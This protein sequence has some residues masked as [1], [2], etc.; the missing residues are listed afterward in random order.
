MLIKKVKLLQS[1]PNV[2]RGAILEKSYFGDYFVTDNYGNTY[3][4]NE[5]VVLE[6][7][8]WFAPYSFTVEDGDVFVG[9]I[10]HCVFDINPT[11]IESQTVF[12][13][14]FIKNPGIINGKGFLNREKAEQ[15]LKSLKPKFKLGDI[16]IWKS[17]G[18]VGKVIELRKNELVVD[19]PSN[20]EIPY[21][22]VILAEPSQIL[23]YYEQQGWVKGAKF[24]VNDFVTGYFS[25]IVGDVYVSE[26][27]VYVKSTIGFGSYNIN[28]CELIKEPDYPK[29]LEDIKSHVLETNYSTEFS[30][31][32]V[33]GNS[34]QYDSLLA[35]SLLTVL[36]KAMIDEYNR[37]NNCDWH[38]DWG[39]RKEHY[40]ILREKDKLSVDCFY[41]QFFHL[42]FP[43]KELAEFSLINHKDLWNQYFQL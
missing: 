10:V 39:S 17:V 7:T 5:C 24:E 30:R 37:V 35:F 41:T 18:T 19:N 13:L 1:L 43:T 33:T 25:G 20:Q 23:K 28:N 6:K 36:H 9:D 26:N 29:S 15:Y 3:T 14:D 27:K 40:V 2:D 22:D 32:I 11:E 31:N 21:E 12:K 8:D 38:P 34:T 16:V 42:A 4:V